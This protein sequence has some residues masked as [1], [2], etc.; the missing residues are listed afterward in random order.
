MRVWIIIDGEKQ[1]PFSDYEIRSKIAYT[2]IKKDTLIWYTG[3]EKWQVIEDTPAFSKDFND[4]EFQI[5]YKNPNEELEDP[6]E[7]LPINTPAENH[8]PEGEKIL[9]LNDGEVKHFFI[10]RVFARFLDINLITQGYSIFII[11]FYKTS[12]IVYIERPEVII[13]ICL[14]ILL[15]DICFHFAWGT[16]IGKL[17]LGLKIEQTQKKLPSLGSSIL[18]AIMLYFC[19]SVICIYF[20]LGFFLILALLIFSVKFN[21]KLPWDQWTNTQAR[22]LP[23]KK[24]HIA[25]YICMFI[26]LQLI[27]SF[28]TPEHI[29]EESIK[30]FEKKLEQ[31]KETKK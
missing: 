14:I 2:E 15:Y 26:S 18:R 12:P 4:G 23:L 5:H 31:L 9:T 30:V 28:T 21:K 27:V 24:G 6:E 11:I 13:S 19:V 25:S 22:G 16:T 10:R 29:K 3:L 17:L 1:G 7:L 8:T 20:P